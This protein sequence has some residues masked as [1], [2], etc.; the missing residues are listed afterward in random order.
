MRNRQLRA[1][2]TAC[3]ASTVLALAVACTGGGNSP[4]GGGP[5]AQGSATTLVMADAPV[6]SVSNNFNPFSPQNALSALDT[7]T[8][9][10]EPLLQWNLL[11]NNTYYPWLA[12][13]FRWSNGGKSITFNLRPNVAWSDGHSFTSADVAF[14]F[15]LIKK[16]PALN[17]NG[18]DFS[19]V[20]APDPHTVVFTFDRPEYAELYYLSSQVIVPQHVWAGIHNPATYTD[21]Q[22]IGTGPYL[23]KSFSPQTILLARNS[24]FWM[25][26]KPEVQYVRLPALASNTTA[27]QMLAQGQMHWGGFFIPNIKA[28]FVAKDPQ[29]NNAWFPPDSEIVMMI[30]NLAKSP[31]D[32]VPVRKAISEALDRDL[33]LRVG[34]QGEAAPDSTPTGLVLPAQQTY[35][36]PQYAQLRFAQ[37]VKDANAL[38]DRAGFKRGAGG[39]RIGPDGRPMSFTLT[40]PSSYTDWM[41][42]SQIVEQNLRRIGIAV[43]VRGVSVSLYTSDIANG[44]FDMSF[45][46]TNIGPTPYYAYSLLDTNGYASVGKSSDTDPERWNDPATTRALQAFAST[47]STQAQVAAIHQLETIMVTQVPVIPLFYN[48]VQA[49]W[50][51]KQ[52]TG[53]PSPKDPY[54]WPAYGPENEIVV[55][56]L[57]PHG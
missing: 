39:V 21:P 42:D 37:N 24:R 48:A 50:S 49:E 1:A 13:A 32:L 7:P 3:A 6:G 46:F 55:L 20:S 27:V 8:F 40:L 26:G 9:V 44:S 45:V 10:Y 18:I 54:A 29:H 47:N 11:K 31:F 14:T 41:A 5:Q 2:S 51:T 56:R 15:N 22:P 57:H 38:L 36:A 17:I 19:T 52:F 12:T 25:P 4:A 35:L 43:T 16:N 28:S 33:I 53:F 30:L 34:E 23:V